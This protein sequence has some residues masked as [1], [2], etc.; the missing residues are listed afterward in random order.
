MNAILVLVAACQVV[1]LSASMFTLEAVSCSQ[2]WAASW[3]N[4]GQEICLA[5]VNLIIAFEVVG[6]IIPAV[7][8]CIA[9]WEELQTASYKFRGDIIVLTGIKSSTISCERLCNF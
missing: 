6:V 8:F 1:R 7:V 5:R 2:S 3:S 9:G 4:Y